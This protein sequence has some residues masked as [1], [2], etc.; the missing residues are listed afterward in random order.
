MFLYEGPYF[1]LV[2]LFYKMTEY[3]LVVFL[4]EYHLLVEVLVIIVYLWLHFWLF[5][6]VV[7]AF[8]AG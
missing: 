7:C 1:Q 5:K 3:A 6:S 2:G 4:L 8:Q